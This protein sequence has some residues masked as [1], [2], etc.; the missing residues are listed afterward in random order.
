MPANLESSA[1]ATGWENIIFYSKEGQYP[2]EQ[3]P[4]S[5]SVSLSHQEACISLL[6][7]LSEGRQNK[8]YNHRKLTELITWT[9][10][11]FN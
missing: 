1:V 6:P 10:V 11:L 5:P 4:V 9:T 8:N 3:D 2:S 7:Y